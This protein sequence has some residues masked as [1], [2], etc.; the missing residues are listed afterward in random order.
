VFLFFNL[1]LIVM[2]DSLSCSFTSIFFLP[3]WLE[4]Q[5]YRGFVS[6]YHKTFIKND[7]MCID[8]I[9]LSVAI[10]VKY[11]LQ[12]Q[13]HMILSSNLLWCFNRQQLVSVVSGWTSDN[14][15][16]CSEWQSLRQVIVVCREWLSLTI[17]SYLSCVAEPQTIYCSLCIIKKC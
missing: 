8:H 16:A 12:N 11:Y 14:L 5:I 6:F 15:F 1:Y 4:I 13:Y 7:T 10:I 2:L 9:N 3:K 17:F